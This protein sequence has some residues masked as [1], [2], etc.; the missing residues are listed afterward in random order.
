MQ[1]LR[2]NHGVITT[3]GAMRFLSIRLKSR[4]DTV[5][6]APDVVAVR[7]TLVEKDDIADEATEER[8]GCSAVV[9]YDDHVVDGVVKDLSLEAKVLVHG[10]LDEPLYVRL[11]PIAPSTAMKPVAGDPQERY[12]TGIVTQLESNDAYATL[13]GHLPKLTTALGE[14]KAVVKLRDGLYV[15]EAMALSERRIALDNGRRVYNLMYS[16]LQVLFPGNN[17]LVDTFFKDL[18]GGGATEAP[19][20][21]DKGGGTPVK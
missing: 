3:L 10:V 1:K 18:R 19:E 15:K 6:L 5:H 11:F 16:R 8:V 14:L 12:V 4:P 9:A 17:A 20:P 13:R 2:E 7:S 21:E